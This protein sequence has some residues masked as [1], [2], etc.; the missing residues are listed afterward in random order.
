MWDSFSRRQNTTLSISGASLPQCVVLF[1]T[2]ISNRF[3]SYT[4]IFVPVLAVQGALTAS[5][6]FLC[7]HKSLQP[8]LVLWFFQQ[9]SENGDFMPSKSTRSR[10]IYFGNFFQ[11]FHSCSNACWIQLFYRSVI[12]SSRVE[13]YFAL[14]VDTFTLQEGLLH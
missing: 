10:T 7:C 5:L 11:P 1:G 2:G 6:T 12:I 3:I 13:C 14:L 9:D 4:Y 8:I